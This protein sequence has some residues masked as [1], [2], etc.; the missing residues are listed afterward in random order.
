MFFE[1]RDEN[2]IPVTIQ[3]RT[4]EN[5]LPTTKVLPFSE[6]N[7]T[8]AEVNVSADGSVA[9][10]FDFRA[11]VYL[12]GGQEYCVTLLSGLQHSIVCLFLELEKLTL[13]HRH[14]FQTNHILDLCLSHKMD[15]HGNQVSGK[16][17]S[18]LYTEQTLLKRVLL[19]SMD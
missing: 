14:L 12:E 7:L 2:D 19:N 8:P 4:M 17:L 3:V 5:G 11:P 18:S 13:L 10:T 16:I 6:V 15:L 9:T 1:T